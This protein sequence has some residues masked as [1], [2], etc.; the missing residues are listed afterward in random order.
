L[1]QN[2]SAR[3]RI[4]ASARR[5]FAERGFHRTAMADLA[6]DAQVSVGAIYRSFSSKSEIIRAIVQADTE[7]TLGQLCADI[8]QVQRGAI[9]GDAAVERM[10]LDWVSKRSDA[11]AHEIV[12]EGH[13]NPEVAEIVTAV[14]SQFREAFRQLARI[15]RPGLDATEI[16]GV[17]E[18]LLACL[19][20]MGNRQFTGPSL[21][22]LETAA[23]VTRL[24]LRGLGPEPQA[25]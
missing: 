4:V 1:Q 22:E 17:A 2:A 16:E 14:C 18:L 7:E 6:E 3:E 19:F 15:L 9:S 13:R 25:I 11:L 12:A 5:L 23:A 21:D 8:D 10:I 20:G 24:I